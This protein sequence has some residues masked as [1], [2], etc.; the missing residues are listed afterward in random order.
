MFEQL[1]EWDRELFIYLNG[2]GIERLDSFWIF[3]TQEENWIP[4]YLIFII[5][6]FLAYKKKQA[7]RGNTIYQSFC[8]ESATQ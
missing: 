5:L 6:I 8:S 3:I 4:L 2:L 7:I 1:K